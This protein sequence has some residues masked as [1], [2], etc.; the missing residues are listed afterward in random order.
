MAAVY[1]IASYDITDP[2]RYERDYV[3]AV[4][5]T[6]AAAGGE[7]V[8]ASG[9]ARRLEGAAPG[10]TVVLRF[11]SEDAFRSWYDGDDYA[12]LLQ[13]R[14]DT[15]TNGTAVLAKESPGAVPAS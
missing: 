15:T 1:F 3:P 2:D 9:S 11:P 7:V 8:V 5:R 4:L 6:L 10:Q 13:L 14:L 12:P